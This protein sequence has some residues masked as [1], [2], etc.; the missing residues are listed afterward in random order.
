MCRGPLPPVPRRATTDAE[1]NASKRPPSLSRYHLPKRLV[2]RMAMNQAIDACA[3]VVP[4]LGDMFDAS[5][6][7]NTKNLAL[8][9]A[10]LK[11]PREAKRADGYFLFSV[12]F[13]V[14]V[15]PFLAVLGVI[16]AIV[17]GIL[18]AVGKIG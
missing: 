16:A 13:V 12:F 18:A 5:F 2:M 10:H 4:F 3:G 6:K 8:L 14:V 1:R 17:V 11:K 15:L 7:A 9:Q